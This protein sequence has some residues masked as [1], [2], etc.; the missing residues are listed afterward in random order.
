[1]LFI[2]LSSGGELSM[3]KRRRREKEKR[4]RKK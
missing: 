4:K 2:F 1:M 3:L